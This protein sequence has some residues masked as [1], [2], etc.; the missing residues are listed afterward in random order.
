MNIGGRPFKYSLTREEFVDLVEPLLFKTVGS[1]ET[2]CDEAEIEYSDLDKIL[3]VGGSTRMP[4]VRESIDARDKKDIKK[5]YTVDFACNKKLKLTVAPDRRYKYPENT[6]ERNKKIII[7]GFGPAGMF[8]GLVLAQMG[9]RPIIIERGE[10]VDTRTKD[11]Q[12]FWNNGNLKENSNVQFGEGGAGT[13]LLC[14]GGA[15]GVKRE[16]GLWALFADSEHLKKLCIC[17]NR[18]LEP[19]G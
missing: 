8:S 19:T 3:L 14:P 13:A 12:D 5:V 6:I 16:T 7:T 11:V 1:M 18:I 15:G 4:I 10:D 17:T 2:A 9:Y